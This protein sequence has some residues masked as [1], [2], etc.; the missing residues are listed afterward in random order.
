MDVVHCYDTSS[1]TIQEVGHNEANDLV[2]STGE[3]GY[4][5]HNNKNIFV[6]V[7]FI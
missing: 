2:S 4:L 1:D 7:C 3:M 6:I 5:Q